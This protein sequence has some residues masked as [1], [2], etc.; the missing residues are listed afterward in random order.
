MLGPER[1]DY[2]AEVGDR[3]ESLGDWSHEE[4]ERVLRDLQ[5]ER[6]LSS[7]QAFQPVRAAVTGT[8]VSPPLFESIALLGRERTL[9]RL[10]QAVAG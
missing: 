6:G 8:L 1:G 7:N 9:S 10:R 5:S 3:L 2:L 4:I